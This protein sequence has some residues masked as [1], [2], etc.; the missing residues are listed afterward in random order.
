L[1]RKLIMIIVVLLYTAPLFAQFDFPAMGGTSAAMGGASV[2]LPDDESALHN[3]AG[4]SWKSDVTLMLSVR[5]TFV[6]EG[7]G[8]ASAGFALPLTFGTCAASVVHYGNSDYNEQMASVC[9]A[10]PIGERISLGAAFHYLHSGT[11]DPYY[12]PI[13]RFTFSVALQY[14]DGDDLMVGFKAYNPIAVFSE[15]NSPLRIPAVFNMGVSYRLL[16]DFMAVVE[17]E[18]NLYAKPTLKVGLSYLFHEY[19][20]FRIGV[21][22]QPVVYSFGFGLN[23]SHFGADLAMQIHNILG[24]MPQVSLHYSF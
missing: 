17:A 4:L 23:R 19:Y 13:N 7:L 14:K 20:A 12:S 1:S 16:P 9:Y 10:M 15:D 24:M 2:A 18:K 21:N 6:V 8:Y 5:Q 22:T 11:S 3:I